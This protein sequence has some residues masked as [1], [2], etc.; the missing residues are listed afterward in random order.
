MKKYFLLLL[1]AS[2]VYLASAQDRETPYYT[3]SLANDGIKAVFVNTS[4]GSISV[5]GASTQQPHIDVYVVGNN[6]QNLTKDEIKKRLE[7]DYILD[8]N[9]QNGELHATAKSR[10]N[11]M[12]WRRS[13]SIGFK[14]YV[15]KQ[16]T[17]NLN[18]SG[19]SLHLDNLTGNQ[20][21]ETSGGSIHADGLTGIIKG[22]TSG[23]SI[24]VSNCKPDIDLETSGG[25]VT[26]DN[27]SGK[28]RLETSGG[29]LNL[30]D[31]KGTIKATTSGGSVRGNNIDGEL[32]T[33]T[34]G[35]SVNLMAMAG[36]VDASTSAGSMHVQMLRV[37][38]YVKIDANS[39][40]VDLQLPTSQGVDVDLR[41]NN[42]NFN[43]NGKFE[44]HKEKERVTG[45]VNG[46]GSLVEVRGDGTVNVNTK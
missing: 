6:N 8:I 44:G 7:E 10:R 45:K 5:S 27:C 13:L 15:N 22:Q 26:A 29:S 20:N 37:G 4:G 35:G 41:G 43:I 3:R 14:V 38:S 18:T 28:I 36:S 39:G 32:V 30:T 11:N 12:N 25:S 16:T 1:M 34:S 33:G 24:H 31:L 23:G 40:H 17:T 21:F 2:P 19:G 46:G 42:V 9:I